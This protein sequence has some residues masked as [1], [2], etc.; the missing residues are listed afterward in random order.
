MMLGPSGKFLAA[1]VFYFCFYFVI[2]Q[3]QRSNVKVKY[4]FLTNKATNKCNTSI[5]FNFD[6][7]IH[8]WYYLNNS[9]SSS[10]S[11]GPFEGQIDEN[12]IFN[13]HNYEQ[14]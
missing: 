1:D 9:M 10:R 12:V 11:K 3:G 5:S 14:T 4:D 8:F 13:K 6:W 7:E 2:I